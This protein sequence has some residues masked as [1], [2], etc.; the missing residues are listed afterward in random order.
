VVASLG[1]G[2]VVNQAKEYRQD[3]KLVNFTTWHTVR[4]EVEPSTMT[5]TYYI[6]GQEIHSFIPKNS[7]QLKSERFNLQIGIVSDGRNSLTGY[8]DDIS[9]GQIR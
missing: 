4:I 1:C 5:L 6:D 3:G 8:I 9:V 2:Y 7:E